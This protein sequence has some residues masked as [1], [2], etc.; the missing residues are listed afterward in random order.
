MFFG[1]FGLCFGCQG[2]LLGRQKRTAKEKIGSWQW[3]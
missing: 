2:I 1:D 3:Q